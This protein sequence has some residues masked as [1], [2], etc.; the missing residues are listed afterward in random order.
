MDGGGCGEA[1]SP[2]PLPSSDSVISSGAI[3]EREISGNCRLWWQKEKRC[4]AFLP[5][6]RRYAAF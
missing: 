6:C 3:A 2:S 5:Y 1:A 4:A